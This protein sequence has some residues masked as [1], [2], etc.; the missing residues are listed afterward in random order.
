[1]DTP[2][3]WIVTRDRSS[4]RLHRR[5]KT[6]HSKMADARCNLPRAGQY[7]VVD[8]PTPAADPDTLCK[9]CFRDR[10]DTA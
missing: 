9:F 7:D 6:D 5:L 1:M 3:E 4:G 2:V 10:F 8:E